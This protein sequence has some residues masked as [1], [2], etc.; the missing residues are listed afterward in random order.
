V[1]IDSRDDHSSWSTVGASANIIEA[2][3]L[4]LVDSIEH[5]LAESGACA[6]DVPLGSSTSPRPDAAREAAGA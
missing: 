4:A 1:L 5:G 2:S 6:P 3:F